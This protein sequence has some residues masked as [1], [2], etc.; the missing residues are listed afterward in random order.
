MTTVSGDRA[1]MSDAVLQDY[2]TKAYSSGI[3]PPAGLAPLVRAIKSSDGTTNWVAVRYASRT[4]LELLGLFADC[5]VDGSDGSEAIDFNEWCGA[6]PRLA[7]LLEMQKAKRG[8]SGIRARPTH[9]H[10]NA[11]DTLARV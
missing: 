4:T 2:H 10:R 7:A 5:D 3:Q 1:T 11:T 6:I 9:V 8:A